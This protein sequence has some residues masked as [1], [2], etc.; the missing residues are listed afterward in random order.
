MILLI[1]LGINA[2]DCPSLVP[3]YIGGKPSRYLPF[4]KE[5]IEITERGHATTRNLFDRYKE[6]H[7]ACRIPVENLSS[8]ILLLVGEYDASLPSDI[9]GRR[10]YER[11]RNQGKNDQCDLTIYPKAGHLIEPPYMPLCTH[12]YQK[13]FGRIS[14]WGGQPKPHARAQ[15]AWSRMIEF[16]KKNLLDIVP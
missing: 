7:E 5:Q 16:F 1:I 10:I 13:E 9:F 11:F 6:E 12:S 8:K 2:I 14:E 15:D 4:R 3:V